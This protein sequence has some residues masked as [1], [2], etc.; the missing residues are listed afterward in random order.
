LPP[1]KDDI[2]L[3]FSARMKK[4]P[5]HKVRMDEVYQNYRSWAEFLKK[6]EI[7]YTTFLKNVRERYQVSKVNK[8]ANFLVGYK[9]KH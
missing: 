7:G 3:F 6:E 5:E 1:P 4:S 2:F 8:E 9:V